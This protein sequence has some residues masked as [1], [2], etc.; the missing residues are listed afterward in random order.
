[1]CK[2]FPQSAWAHNKAARL[3]ARCNRDL[4]AA[5]DHARKGVELEPDDAGHL[6]TLAEVYIQRG[7]KVKAVELMK[8]CIEM[9][10]RY[11]YFRKQL[12]RMQAGDRDADVPPSRA[13]PAAAPGSLGPLRSHVVDP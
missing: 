3:A 7:D 2:E 11:E 13:P 9:Q 1:V 10:P 12:Q 4:D 8:K 6:D 5:L